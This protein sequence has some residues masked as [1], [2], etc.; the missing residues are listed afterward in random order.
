MRAFVRAAALYNGAGIVVMLTPGGLGL[1]GVTVPYSPFWVWLG[2][3]MGLFATM[4]LWISS[5][6]LEKYGTFP[7]WNGIVRMTFVVATFALDFGA[8]MGF[9]AVALA[10]GD[11]VLS[12]GCIFGLPRAVG[13]SHWELLTGAPHRPPHTL[14]AAEI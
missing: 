8:T 3:L 14:G 12:L 7:Y 13:R 1:V 4:A 6:D 11:V 9:F 5:R 10:L 2:A